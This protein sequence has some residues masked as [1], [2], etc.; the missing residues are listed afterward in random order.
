MR[1][2]DKS[3]DARI[4]IAQLRP[5]IHVFKESNNI[6]LVGEYKSSGDSAKKDIMLKMKRYYINFLWE[7]DD[8]EY[9]EGNTGILLIVTKYPKKRIEETE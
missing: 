4:H 3:S 8:D 7:I 6:N 9:N 2:T 1:R 5:L